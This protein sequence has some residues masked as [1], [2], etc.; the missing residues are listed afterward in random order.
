MSCYHKGLGGLPSLSLSLDLP[1][2]SLPLMYV[3]EMN[4]ALSSQ[5]QV[6]GGGTFSSFFSPF[7]L[8]FLDAHTRISVCLRR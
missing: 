8:L 1:S 3:R 5:D 7:S 6:G 2:P 4:L